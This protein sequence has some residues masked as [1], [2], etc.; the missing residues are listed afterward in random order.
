MRV[1]QATSARARLG[2][3]LTRTHDRPF[4]GREIDLGAAEGDLRQDGRVGRAAPRHDRRRARA[5]EEPDRRRARRLR[6]RAARARDVASGSVPAVWGGDHVLGARRDREG[7]R[8]DPGVRPAAVASAKL[9]AR[10]ARRGRS[11]SG[12]A[13]GSCRCS[14]SRASSAADREELFTAWRR[15]LEL[16]AEERPTVLVFEDLHWADEAMLAFLEHLADRAERVPLLVVATARPELFE[17][18]RDYAAGLRNATHDQPGAAFGRGDRAPRLGAARDDRAPG[19][20]AAADPRAG[21][22][23]PALRRGV[24]PAA[25]GSRPARAGTARRGSSGKAPR[26]RSPTRCRP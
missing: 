15:F 16:I 12:S 23:Q 26:C 8:R 9:E 18:R 2:T 7:A 5:R 4:V 10:A 14:G 1:F 17:R 21:R 25:E 3:D 11:A 13:S 20:A 24:R 22:G 19:R 6:R